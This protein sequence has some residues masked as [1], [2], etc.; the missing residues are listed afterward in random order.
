MIWGICFF[1]AVISLAAGAAVFFIRR[2]K[3]RGE[4]KYLGAGVF[5]AWLHVFRGCVSQTRRGSR[6]Q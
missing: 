1:L 2:H 5:L 4:I 3:E 6:L